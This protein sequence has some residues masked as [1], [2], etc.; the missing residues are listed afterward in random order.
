LD[1]Q[2]NKVMA[3]RPPQI[4]NDDDDFEIDFGDD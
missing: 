4:Q 3:P 2:K 1:I